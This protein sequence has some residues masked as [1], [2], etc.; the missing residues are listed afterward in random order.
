MKEPLSQFISRNGQ[1]LVVENLCYLDN[2]PYSL[3]IHPG[4][5]VGLSGQSGVGK[6]QLL[7][8]L[9]DLSTWQ[10]R[11]CY[12]QHDISSIPAMQWRRLVAY[13]PA[14]SAWW[15]D[16]VAEHFDAAGPLGQD[17]QALL[18]QLG[19]S[20]EVL[21]WSIARLSSGEKQRLAIF[22]TLINQPQVLL[23]DEPTSNL[24]RESVGKVERLL[25]AL[26]EKKRAVLIV[27]HDP[28][29]LTRLADRQY[30]MEKDRLTELPLSEKK[31]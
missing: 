7:R 5:I 16:T 8:A 4:E 3:K 23:L 2:G 9:V 27:S 18:F 1:P 12:G 22:R 6:S 17:E 11:I 31:E 10:G 25:V 24:D 13:I 14:E 20:E 15:Y 19:F 21:H 29:Q 30:I 26:K 28:D